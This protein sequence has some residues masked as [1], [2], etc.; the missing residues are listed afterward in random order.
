MRQAYIGIDIG[1]SG[2]KAIAIDEACRPIAI[3][4]ERYDNTIVYLGLGMYDQDPAILREASFK[5]CRALLD[6]LGADYHVSALGLTGQM[7]GLVALG[8]RLQPLR[9]IISCVDFRNEAQND[10]IYAAVGGKTGLLDYTNNKMVP[11]CTG[12]KIL[13]LMEHEPELFARTQVILNP[14]DYIRTALTGIPVTEESDASGFGL[15][16]VKNRCWSKALLERIGIPERVLPQVL[17]SYQ[18]V[19]SVLPEVAAQ[20]G[21]PDDVAVVAGAGDAIMQTCGAGAV[22]DGVYS[23]IVGSGGN[24]STAIDHCPRNEGALL[25]LYAGITESQWVAYAGLMSVGTSV[26]WFREKFYAS[27][28][29]RGTN[30]AFAVMEQEA[31]SVPAGSEGLVFLPSLMGQRNPVD[32]PFAKGVTVGFSLLHGRGHLYRAL[33]EGLALGM[34]ELYGLLLAV[35]KPAQCLQI[36]G[37]GAASDTWCQIFADVFQVPVRRMKEYGAAGAFGVALLAR[38]HDGSP[39]ELTTLMSDPPTDREFYPNPENRT[40]YDDLFAIY[41]SVYPA[42]CPLFPALKA[43]EEKYVCAEREVT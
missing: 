43:F 1:S 11:S 22:K 21:L 7:H 23:I 8:E 35:A 25:Q 28:S 37:G 12:G 42:V 16:D 26:N 33:L 24:I 3:A 14:K 20:L 4:S 41:R 10:R 34:R 6:K 5:C 9:P 32:D 19:G 36:S 17:H 31:A 18:T 13:W 30:A 29:A 39:E 27:E 15:Y 2:C 40:V 38:N